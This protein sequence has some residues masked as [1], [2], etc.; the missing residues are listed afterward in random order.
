MKKTLLKRNQLCWCGSK[1][2]YKACHLI[3]D[4]KQNIERYFIPR[5]TEFF[6]G[7][8]AANRLVK[9][10]FQELEKFTKIGVT[11]DELNKIAH[12][13][14]LDNN[15]V[16][17]SLGYQGFPKSIC[18]S[19]NSVICHGIP[20]EIPL[21][22]GDLISIDVACKL[23]GYYGDA[24]KSFLLGNSTEISK[25]LVVVTKECL[26]LGIKAVK[27]YT[28][29][30]NIGFAIQEHAE[31][32]GFSVVEKFVGHGI[33]TQFHTEPQILHYGVRDSKKIIPGS[34]FT[35]EPMINEGTKKL[36]ILEDDWTAVTLDG[37][38]SA[39]FEHTI[40]MK[41]DGTVN[42]LTA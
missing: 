15:A 11:T 22:D 18:T 34:C 31:K 39:Q 19:V 32:N 36:K 16:P 10:T 30:S 13:F 1:K 21:Q 40:L 6:A 35:I 41:E 14:I 7:M 4:E 8:Y 37:K 42:V 23:N 24:C 26:E 38:L 25:K 20:N 9:Q 27:P 33:G 2:K 17:A 29:L 28:N 3:S 12:E 5:T